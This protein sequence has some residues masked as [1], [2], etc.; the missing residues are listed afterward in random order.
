MALQCG[1][2]LG[3]EH[4][5]E[6]ILNSGMNRATVFAGAIACAG[7]RLAAAQQAL[8]SDSAVRA[9]LAQRITTLPDSGKHGSGIVVGL[10]D[11]GGRRVVAAGVAPTQVVEIGSI[12]KVF[13]ASLLADMVARGE[14]GV[15]DPVAKF[16]P[17]TVR[18]PA[19]NG[20]Q[21]T[22]GD[23][24]TQPAGAAQANGFRPRR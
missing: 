17:N 12:T 16:F 5:G 18:G 11:A 6:K 24:P 22:L 19:R 13:T 21:S 23:L 8:P 10:L 1:D 15:D 20:R 7:V 2:E 9:L 3:D 4:G 14:G